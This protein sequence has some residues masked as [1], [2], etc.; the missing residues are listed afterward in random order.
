MPWGSNWSWRCKR[1]S[2]RCDMHT[3]LFIHEV[4]TAGEWWRDLPPLVSVVGEPLPTSPASA[5][6]RQSQLWDQGMC[7]L[8]QCQQLVS[9]GDTSIHKASTS[10]P[11]AYDPSVLCRS[12]G[13]RA[14]CPRH[15]LQWH[16]L[17]KTKHLLSESSAPLTFF[18]TRRFEKKNIHH[19]D[20]R[21]VCL[22]WDLLHQ[23]CARIATQ[24][25]LGHWSSD[26]TFIAMLKAQMCLMH[27]RSI[28]FCL[29]LGDHVGTCN[30]NRCG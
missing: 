22:L 7:L 20:G 11:G 8:E 18:F 29:P 30:L 4:P 3:H 12:L 15:V 19:C 26:V 14:P 6:T 21:T 13:R 17:A 28:S 5:P 23:A 10:L 1:R 27:G 24:G 16:A 25:P 2:H 9:L